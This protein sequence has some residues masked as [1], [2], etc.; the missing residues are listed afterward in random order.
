MPDEVQITAGAN[1]QIE[2]NASDADSSNV[3]FAVQLYSIVNGSAGPDVNNVNISMQ[4][5]VLQW[6]SIPETGAGFEVTVTDQAGA[7][8]QWRPVIKFCNCL[9]GAQCNFEFL[10]SNESAESKCH[11]KDARSAAARDTLHLFQL[12]STRVTATVLADTPAIDVKYL[13]ATL[14]QILATIRAR[15]WRTPTAMPPAVPVRPAQQATAEEP[16]AVKVSTTH[17]QQHS[18]D[19]CL[20]QSELCT[21]VDECIQNGNTTCSEVCV[22]LDPGYR[23]E[24]STP[25]YQIDPSNSSQCIG[26]TQMCALSMSRCREA[27][28]MTN[29]LYDVQCTCMS[30]L[31]LLAVI[32]AQQ[33]L[34][35]Q[36]VFRDPSVYFCVV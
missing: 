24:C 22:N 5:N 34:S 16:T 28:N 4:N 33:K 20:V 9:N 35:D 23:C 15:A 3:T 19:D 32:S 1:F 14:N 18:T 8:S 10:N 29:A 7:E 25:G 31:L 21:D 2:V 36:T 11:T 6:D 26:E 27:R 13:R 12:H 17:Q 30:C